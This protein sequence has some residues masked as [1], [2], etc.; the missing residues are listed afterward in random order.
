MAHVVIGDITPRIQYVGNGSVTVFAYP[1]PIFD[2]T[3]LQ[4]YLDD[5]LQMSGYTVTGA[6]ESDGGSA[7]FSVAP[8]DGVVVTLARSVPIERTT[9][10]Q[11]GGAFRAAVINE[12][13]DRIVATEQQLKEEQAR[14]V[15]RPTTSTSTASLD[16]PDPV[17]GRALKFALDGALALSDGDPDQAQAD[18]AAQVVLATAQ[19]VLAASYASAAEAA[20]DS[21]LSSL[22][23]FDDRYL[24]AKSADPATDNDGDPLVA[25]AL[26]FNTTDEVMKLYTG[27]AWVAAYVSGADYLLISNALSELSGSAAAARSNIGAAAQ[28]DL[29]ALSAEVAA[30]RVYR[31]AAVTLSG[32]AIVFSSSG[33]VPAS[34]TVIGATLHYARMSTSGT[35]V[36]NV[37]VGV[38]SGTIVST[39][40]QAAAARAGAS[41]AIAPST[42]GFMLVEQMVESASTNGQIEFSVDD[43][44]CSGSTTNYRTST[45]FLQ[46]GG[47]S[48]ALA[49]LGAIQLTT[50][51]GTDTF[52][53]GSAWVDWLVVP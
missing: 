3:D 11:D 24:G 7:T 50:A 27:S 19:A 35:S 22:D 23:N 17:A 44:W 38:D 34:A 41:V 28:V 48:V 9:D 45:D 15:K 6:G 37:R 1:F 14:T 31:S 36:Y 47:G 25:G 43:G 21:A 33:V 4:V 30:S 12:E 49:S 53:A 5:A 16:L 42:T 2:D 39:G 26:Y 8:G 32:T 29:A 10:F 13:L 40:Y 52:D 18:A 51:G 20:R 46:A